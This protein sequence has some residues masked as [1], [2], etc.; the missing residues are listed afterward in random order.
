MD[1]G[2][3]SFISIGEGRHHEVRRLYGAIGH[4]ILRLIRV[5]YGPVRLGGLVATIDVPP[6]LGV[7]VRSLFGDHSIYGP[8]GVRFYTRLKTITS[9]W[10]AGLRAG[11]DFAFPTMK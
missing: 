4:P 7:A 3:W 1:P 9:R 10:Q 6:S 5:G 8:E 2:Q 11:A